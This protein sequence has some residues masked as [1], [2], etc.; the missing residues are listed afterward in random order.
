MV[1]AKCP[2]FHNC[3]KFALL[4]ANCA[5]FDDFGHSNKHVLALVVA[6]EVEMLQCRHNV[7]RL[8]G[9][10]VAEILYRNGATVILQYLDHH[11]TEFSTAASWPASL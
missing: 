5:P 9:R 8:D 2:P 10:L 7:L 1:I 4:I 3:A 11:M 6:D